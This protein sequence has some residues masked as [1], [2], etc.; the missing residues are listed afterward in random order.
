[1]AA[2]IEVLEEEN[3]RLRDEYSRI[4]QVRYHRTGVAL[5]AVGVLSVLAATIFPNVREILLVLGSIGIFGGILTYYLTPER[6]VS[7]SVG[8]GIV[9]ATSRNLEAIQSELGLTDHRL[10]VPTNEPGTSAVRLYIPQDESFEV[11]A[12][13][14]LT[15]FF[16]VAENDRRRGI[17][18]VPTASALFAEFERARTGDLPDG[19]EPLAAQLTEGLRAQFELI[20]G[21]TFSAEADDQPVTISVSGSSFGSLDNLDHPVVSFLGYGIAQATGQPVEP[22]V[23]IGEDGEYIQFKILE[24]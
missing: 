3:R 18:I 6:F 1:M 8:E 11:P 21:A 5:G 7:A 10:Y 13:E 16:V 17:S 2:E 15:D 14:D 9:T 24:N 12:P 4:T 20:D 23:V 22:S 19:I